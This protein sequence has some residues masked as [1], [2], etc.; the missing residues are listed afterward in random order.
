MVRS[1]ESLHEEY[2]AKN[3]KSLAQWER[4]R[5]TMPAGVIKGAYTR[6]PFPFYVDHSDGC[7][8]TDIDGNVVIDFGSHHSAMI[9]GHTHPDVLAAVQGEIERGLGLG[10]PTDLEAEISEETGQPVS[11]H[12]Q[13]TVHQLRHGVV[14]ARRQAD[15]RQD[16]QAE[17]RQ[18]RGGLSRQPRR[19]GAQHQSADGRRRASGLSRDR[20]RQPRRGTH[21][22][23]PRCHAFIQRPGV[24]RTHPAGAPGRG[25]GCLL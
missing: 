22:R 7:R 14:A 19:L 18:V 6:S 9:L 13:G 12:R 2:T 24:G 23:G 11:F 5:A 25:G 1:L 4:S 8:L 10:N 15:P 16:G 20:A 21:F 17:G 3:P